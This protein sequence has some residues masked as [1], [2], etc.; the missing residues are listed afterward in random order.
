VP[1][2]NNTRL[3][4]EEQDE[5]LISLAEYLLDENLAE[6]AKSCISHV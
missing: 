4:H 1:A 6:F 3:D 2:Y 5:V